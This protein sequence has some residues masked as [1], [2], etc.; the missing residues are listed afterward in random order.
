MQ[1]STNQEHKEGKVCHSYWRTNGK[2]SIR[3]FFM[4]CTWF[5]SYIINP[6]ISRK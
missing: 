6:A 4:G 2:N 3:C 1:N 5:Y